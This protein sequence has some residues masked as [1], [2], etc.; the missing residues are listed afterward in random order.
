M[1][2]STAGLQTARTWACFFFPKPD[3]VRQKSIFAMLV[4]KSQ[5][6]VFGH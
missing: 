1:Q 5:D 6:E 2:F 4:L 3:D